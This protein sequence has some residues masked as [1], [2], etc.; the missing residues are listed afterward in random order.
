MARQATG[1]E[2]IEQDFLAL[3]LPA[4]RFDG[5]FANASLFHVP[6]RELPRVLGELRASLKPRGVLFCS[7]PRGE[8]QEGWRN[9]RYG[10]FW[11][12]ERWRE[13]LTGAGF[14]EV[15][16]YYRPEGKP[17]DEQPWLA[18][19]WRSERRPMLRSLD[20]RS[21][22]SQKQALPTIRHARR[23]REARQSSRPVTFQPSRSK[24]RPKS[25]VLSVP[26]KGVEP[27]T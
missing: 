23:S 5:I 15:A 16:H 10:C 18:T 6:G 20:C 11:D 17:R 7:N 26:E 9:G 13:I 24:F 4:G 1:C 14:A 19:V 27:L 2:V 12:L 3:S 22:H 25:C 8:N 21:A